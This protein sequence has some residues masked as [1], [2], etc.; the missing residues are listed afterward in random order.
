MKFLNPRVRV[1]SRR[2]WRNSMTLTVD[3][4]L[5]PVALNRPLFCRT[6]GVNIIHTVKTIWPSQHVYSNR[7][8]YISEHIVFYWGGWGD[9]EKSVL[10]RPSM[11]SLIKW[12]PFHCFNITTPIGEVLIFSRIE[13]SFRTYQ[14]VFSRIH[15][16]CAPQR[17]W[18]CRQND[19]KIHTL[20]LA[21][22]KWNFQEMRKMLGGFFTLKII[23]AAHVA[24]LAWGFFAFCHFLNSFMNSWKLFCIL[25]SSG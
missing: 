20:I 13:E 23:Y 11:L 19:W 2:F 9:S 12:Y 7:W 16:S 3:S 21:V 15:R 5:S 14:N 18:A 4:F 10:I 1:F 17:N 24:A 22:Q 25:H 8:R 6:D